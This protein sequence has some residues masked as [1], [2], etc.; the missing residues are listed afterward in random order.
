MLCHRIHSLAAICC[1]AAALAL[2]QPAPAHAQTIDLSLNVFYTTPSNPNSGGT[3]ELVAKSSN[4][5][6]AGLEALITNVSTVENRSPGGTVNGTGGAGFDIYVDAF[7][8][9]AGDTPAYHDLIFGQAQKNL[10]A[11]QEQGAFYGVGQLANGAPNYNGKPAG[12]NS[13]G[14]LLASLTNPTN[15]PWATGDIFNNA[16]WSTAAR[17]ASG[18]FAVNTTPAFLAGSSG[19][20]FMALGTSAVLGNTVAAS[21]IT[22]VVRTN[23]AGLPGDYNHNGIVD[24]ADFVFWRNTQNQNV[25]PSTGA[26]GSGNG[27][28]D[29]A[30][31][32]I[33]RAHFGATMGSGTGGGLAASAVPEPSAIGIF[34]ALAALVAAAIR[35]GR[36]SQPLA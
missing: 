18:T 12:T 20:V 9:A 5:G 7:H 6:I 17:F 36:P 25:T 14:P 8:P 27:V 32:D 13:E 1:A 29:A 34:A 33:W 30:D 22:T 35:P 19:N 11:G 16:A 28:V 3:W 31:Y 2:L 21:A 4:F 15:I 10:T 24:A 26:D 23:L